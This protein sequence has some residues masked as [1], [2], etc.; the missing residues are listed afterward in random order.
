MEYVK[1]KDVEDINLKDWLLKQGF[2]KVKVL[3]EGRKYAF[4]SLFSSDDKKWRFSVSLLDNGRWEW[5]D[6]TI[7]KGGNIIDL[8]MMLN[9][10]PSGIEGRVL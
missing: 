4:P 8:F 9:S 7:G 2:T 6:H 10:L 5:C 3:Q 1:F